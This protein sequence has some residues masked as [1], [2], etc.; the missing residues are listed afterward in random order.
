MR[1]ELPSRRRRLGDETKVIEGRAYAV[2]ADAVILKPG[3]RR[4]HWLCHQRAMHKKGP[5]RYEGI[6]KDN[7]PGVPR[8]PPIAISWYPILL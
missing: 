3:G 8:S 6:P 2:P 7:T 5:G 1:I 4:P